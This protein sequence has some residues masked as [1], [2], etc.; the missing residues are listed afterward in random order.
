MKALVKVLFDE[1]GDGMPSMV[2]LTPEGRVPVRQTELAPEGFEFLEDVSEARWV[3]ESLAQ[4]K[5]G[6]LD[7]M[8]PEGFP[9]YA[10]IFHP[11]H[12]EG[13]M[14]QPV[15]WS[16]VA[17]WTG[18]T[19][20]PQM[21]FERIA[22]LSE[23]PGDIYKD[24]PWGALPQH[25][26]IP[27][28]ECR[29][30]VDVLGGFTSTPEQCFFGLWEGWGN[31]DERLYKADS[32]V[33]APHRDHLLFRGPLDA[34]MS[35]VE[36]RMDPF[37]GKSPSIWWPQDRAWCVTTDVD[38]FDTFVGGSR[39]CIEAVL[40]NLD[41]EALPT[42]HDAGI[43]MAADTVNVACPRTDPGDRRASP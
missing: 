40:G 32:R 22:G 2:M 5:W 39:E 17:S 24:P 23:E 29:A 33:R 12:L 21:Q 38:L 34:V 18:Q 43:S 16:T 14:K 36:E 7:S 31:I 28:R 6:R 9:S 13:D 30:L 25:G 1:S 41:L 20:H 35:F 3:E 10:R 42:T 4:R 15:R 8:M 11:A 37:W 26:S 27:E 19:V